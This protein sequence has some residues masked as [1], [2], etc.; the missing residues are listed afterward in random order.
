MYKEKQEFMSHLERLSK[1]HDL[2]W[3]YNYMY[4][5]SSAMSKKLDENRMLDKDEFLELMEHNYG[6]PEDYKDIDFD[7]E[8]VSIEELPEEELIDIE[9]SDDNLFYAN[10]I[11][12]HNS[13]YGNVD[14]GLET[15]SESIGLVQTADVFYF[16]INSDAMKENNQVL[17]KFE[18]NRN[19]G[20]LSSH[21]M[22]VDYSRMRYT[23]FEGDEMGSYQTQEEINTQS[24]SNPSKD[25][26]DF[27]SIKF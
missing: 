10:D 7:D 22:E 25:D 24:V 8:I 13:A 1:E 18:K 2:G 26:F 16:I 14:A 3:D 20:Q 23:D 4:Q 21:M 19:T 6:N 12:T 9:V 17:I 27:G 11:L 15:V 5:L